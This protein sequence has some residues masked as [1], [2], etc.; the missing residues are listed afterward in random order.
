MRVP[1]FIIVGTQKAGTT[2]LREN[3]FRHPEVTGSKKQIHFFDKNYEKGMKWYCS[4]FEGMSD[5]LCVGEKSTEYFDINTASVVAERIAR[6]CP[7]TRIIVVLREPKARAFSALKH[8]VVM[9][10]E[11]LPADPDALLF[12]DRK[13]LA[14]NKSFRYIERGFY[15]RQLEA[16]FEHI[17]REQLLV[18]IFEEDI[19]ADPESGLRR[20]FSFLGVDPS[21]VKANQKPV[22]SK[23]L[24]SPAIWL[25]NKFVRVPLVR[26]LIWRIDERLPL[27]RWSPVFS[28]VTREKLRSIYAPENEKLF[29]LI[30]RSIKGWE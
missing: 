7:N 11:L 28:D 2:W 27:P 26:S 13:K 23:S 18:V 10:Q 3:L 22:N 19:V 9:G 6:D 4:H 14:S 15:A 21:I 5:G 12:E 30:G 1:D 29:G 20:V 8:T 24:S 17:P 16:Y 25:M